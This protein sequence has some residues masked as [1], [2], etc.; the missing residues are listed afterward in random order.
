[1][2]AAG[3]Y[4][5]GE[6]GNETAVDLDLGLV[7]GAGTMTIERHDYAPPA[8]AFAGGEEPVEVYPYR[9]VIAEEG[10]DGF[11][12]ELR[13]ALDLLPAI[14][15]REDAV[16]YARP[17]EGAGE[18]APLATTCDAGTRELAA[19]VIAPGELLVGGTR[20]V[21]SGEQTAPVVLR[22]EPNRPNPFRR[23]TVV[24]YEL[25]RGGRVRLELYD[26]LGSVVVRLADRV[27]PAGRHQ[28]GLD[29]GRLASGVYFLRLEA[30]GRSWTRKIALSR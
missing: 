19:H 8:L 9:W 10:L 12:G 14:A 27:L 30:G 11:G 16:V 7:S 1:V 20:A 4:D 22:F 2:A 18:F 26:V 25:A 17:A 15:G 21:G 13:F 5:F 23:H 3:R 29:G 28:Q 24:E 6:P